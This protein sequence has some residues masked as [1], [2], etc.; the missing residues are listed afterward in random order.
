M[1]ETPKRLPPSKRHD[2]KIK[3]TDES[4]TVK[5]RPYRYFAVQ[6]NEIERIVAEMKEIGI[7]QDSHSL[8]ASSVIFVKKKDGSWRLCIDYRQLNNITI[9]DKF[10]I[11]LVKELLDELAAARFFFKL[12]LRSSYH[13]IRMN[14]V[15]IHKTAFRTHHDHYE[16][17]VMPFGLTNALSTFKG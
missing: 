16:F 15:D 2:H 11:P 12:D 14:E 7:I 1:F 4:Q 3:L 6:K 10:P 13:Q 17:L 9:K 5:I 8:F